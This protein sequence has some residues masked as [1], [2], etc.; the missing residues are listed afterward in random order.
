[1]L[2][3]LFKVS[4]SRADPLARLPTIILTITGKL[5]LCGM[6]KASTSRADPLARLPTMILTITGKLPLCGPGARVRV[7][8]CVWDSERERECVCQVHLAFRHQVP[9]PAYFEA[10]AVL[11]WAYMEPRLHAAPPSGMAAGGVVGFRL[12]SLMSPRAAV[13]AAAAASFARDFT[14]ASNCAAPSGVASTSDN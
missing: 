2:P 11:P 1:M 8:V 7:Y 14:Q 9:E 10:A 3:K 13:S 5:P 12:T 6:F 4:T